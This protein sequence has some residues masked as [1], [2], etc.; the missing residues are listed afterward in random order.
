MLR[1]MTLEVDRYVLERELGRGSFGAV[2]VARHKV[3]GTH[4]ALKLLHPLQ[5]QDTNAVE[6]FLQEARAA[7]SIGNAHIARVSDAG[8]AADQQVFLAMELLDGEDLAAYMA[9]NGRLSVRD[10]IAIV[11]QVLDGLGAAHAAGIVHR[12][13]KPANVF[14]ARDE[15][16][17]LLV[18]ILD[19]GVSKVHSPQGTAGRLTATGMIV[20]TPHYMAPEQ[21]IE[22]K[23]VDGRADLYSVGVMLYEMLSGVLPHDAESYGALFHQVITS[24]PKPLAAVAPHAPANLVQVIEWALAK[25]PAQRVGSA[26][27]LADWLQR[28]LDGASVPSDL[29]L[30]PTLA[31]HPRDTGPISALPW[32]PS[33]T[34]MVRAPVAATGPMSSSQP[35]A[36]APR[37]SLVPYLA[38]AGLLLSCCLGTGIFGVAMQERLGAAW[39]AF[40]GTPSTTDGPSAGTSTGPASNPLTAPFATAPEIPMHDGNEEAVGST[41]VSIERCSRRRNAEGQWLVDMPVTVR[42]IGEAGLTFQQSDFTADGFVMTAESTMPTLGMYAPG[43]S[44]EGYLVWRASSEMPDPQTITVRFQGWARRIPVGDGPRLPPRPAPPAP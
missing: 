10:A 36:P 24:T 9:R 8:V 37:R 33:T 21:L 16:G 6:R 27:E 35:A 38:A 20:G 28:Q 7:A 26:A 19:F 43:R 31:A 13:M 14:L 23:S 42:N 29:S 22:S 25:D 44:F 17:S 12:D 32:S 40:A 15:R 34:P 39:A 2:Y 3:L 5:A 1:G 18:K 30:P 41:G 4:V 11:L